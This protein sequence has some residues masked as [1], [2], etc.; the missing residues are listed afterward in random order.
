[1]RL[2]T[3]IGAVMAAAVAAS[4]MFVATQGTAQ[5]SAYGCYGNLVGTWPVKS[6]VGN[7]LSHIRLYYNPATGYNCAVNVKTA[8][9]SQFKHDTFVEI[10]RSDWAEDNHRPGVTIDTDSGK[11]KYYAGPVKIPAKNKCVMV[12]ARTYYYDEVGYKYT[13]SVACG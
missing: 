10:M 4:G 9:Y 12:T 1:M 11:Y 8:Y 13:G 6:K 3:R 7:T 2:R 5:A